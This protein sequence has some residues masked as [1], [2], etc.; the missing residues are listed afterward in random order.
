MNDLRRLIDAA[1]NLKPGDKEFMLYY[2]TFGTVPSGEWTAEIGNASS[3]V[4]LG[5]GT[6]EI[7]TA[8]FLTPEEAVD[9]L[10]ILIKEKYG[11]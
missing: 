6:G 3:P 1:I 11:L 4:L 9:S 7:K 10:I 2:S 5:D 8:Y